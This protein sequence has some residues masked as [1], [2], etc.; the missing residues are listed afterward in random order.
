MHTIP[1]WPEVLD[2][3][4]PHPSSSRQ[5][6][7]SRLDPSIYSAD[8][9][10]RLAKLERQEPLRRLLRDAALLRKQRK[11]TQAQMAEE[12]GVPCRTL[13]EWLQ[14]RRYPR[15]PGISLLKRWIQEC[16][17]KITY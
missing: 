3:G 16:E 6:G 14:G 15:G 8:D 1:S 5:T 10:A 12:L 7:S 13:E 2:T 11:I 4:I 17:V 9:T